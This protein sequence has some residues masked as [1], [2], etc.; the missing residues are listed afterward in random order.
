MGFQDLGGEELNNSPDLKFTISA[1]YYAPLEDLPISAFVNLSYQWQDDVNFSLLGDPGA[2]QDSYGV[3]NLNIGIVESANERYSVTLFVNNLFD[4]DYVTSISN[5]GGL[6]GNAPFL[7]LGERFWDAEAELSIERFQTLH[8][9]TGQLDEV[10]LCDQTYAIDTMV[11][12]MKQ[13]GFSQVDVYEA[14]DDLPLY[15]AQEWVVYI[16]Q[17]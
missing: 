15:D 9:E 2:E 14:W 1:E 4:E 17:R 3:A 7:H 13:A 8:L 16:A 5:F 10:V 11:D 6:W 12:M